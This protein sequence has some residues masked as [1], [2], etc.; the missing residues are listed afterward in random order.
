MTE[1]VTEDAVENWIGGR[2]DVRK[3]HEQHEERPVGTERR[4]RDEVIEDRDLRWSVADHVDA[5]AGD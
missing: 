4:R 5:D 2:V 1:I 3:R